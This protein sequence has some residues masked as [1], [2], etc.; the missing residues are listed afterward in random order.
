MTTYA[1]DTNTI[2]YFLRGEGNVCQHMEYEIFNKGN[3]Y[4]IP[5]MVIYEIQR[6]LRDNPTKMMKVASNQFA[7]LLD[8]VKNKSEMPVEMWETAA[9]IYISL[10]TRGLLIGDADILIAAYC[11]TCDYTLVTRNSND[12]NRINGLKIVNWFE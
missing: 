3:A 7:I 2:S 10:K 8:A 5:P 4:A 9:D 1:L 12:F 11:I 6:W